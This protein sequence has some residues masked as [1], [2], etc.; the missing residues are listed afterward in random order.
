MSKWMRVQGPSE[1]GVGYI[2]LEEVIYVTLKDSLITPLD[3]VFQVV[4]YFNGPDSSISEQFAT[5][6]ERDVRCEEIEK[7]LGI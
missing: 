3:E 5:K 6:E 7:L 1:A 4:Y 2:N